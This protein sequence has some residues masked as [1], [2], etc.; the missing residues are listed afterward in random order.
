MAK[1]SSMAWADQLSGDACNLAAVTAIQTDAQ[2]HQPASVA[3][4]AAKTPL[5]ADDADQTMFPRPS[6]CWM[7]GRRWRA[8]PPRRLSTESEALAG[9]AGRVHG[10]CGP[11]VTMS[12]RSMVPQRLRQKARRDVPCPCATVLHR[13]T[14]LAS[15]RLTSPR[16]RIATNAHSWE[17]QREAF[18]FT[19][20]AAPA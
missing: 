13:T 9:R 6:M 18:V 17:W 7:D 14:R 12:A 19:C 10:H 4:R 16:T 1:G 11:M 20:A 5:V 3:E 8:Q 15:P 2:P